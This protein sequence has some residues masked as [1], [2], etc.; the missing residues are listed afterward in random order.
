[1][2]KPNIAL[3][4]FMGTGKTYIGQLLAERLNKKF[5]ETDKIIEEVA[6]KT[7][8]EIFATEGEIRFRDHAVLPVVHDGAVSPCWR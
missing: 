8:P 7:I 3:I 6:K 4:G 5:I 2:P 1:M